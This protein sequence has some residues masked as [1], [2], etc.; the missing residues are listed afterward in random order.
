MCT[1]T[2]YKCLLSLPSIFGFIRM[3]TFTINY[4]VN[5]LLGNARRCVNLSLMIDKIPYYFSDTSSKE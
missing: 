1:F 5:K 2:L 4:E 3:S